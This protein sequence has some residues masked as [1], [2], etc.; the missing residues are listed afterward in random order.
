MPLYTVK[1]Y[2]I[3]ITI[4]FNNPLKNAFRIYIIIQTHPIQI[5]RSIFFIEKKMFLADF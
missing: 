3:C 5:V 1:I 4:T 2:F